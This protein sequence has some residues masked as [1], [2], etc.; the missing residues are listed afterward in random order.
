MITLYGFG[1]IFPE[2]VG[3]RKTSGLNGRSRKPGSP[4]ESTR[5]TILPASSSQK[6]AQRYSSN[7]CSF[8]RPGCDEVARR[9]GQPEDARRTDRARILVPVDGFVAVTDPGWY[10]RL[11]RTPGPK[12]ANIERDP[13]PPAG[14]HRRREQRIQRRRERPYWQM[15]A[16][17][18]PLL[19]GVHICPLGHS[20][21]VWHT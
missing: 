14:E 5:S 16:M 17:V 9:G 19:G 3:K 21:L 1:R 6:P 10:E 12:D 15:V 7:Q 20:A 13:L 18:R 2:G 4:T 8:P 11:S